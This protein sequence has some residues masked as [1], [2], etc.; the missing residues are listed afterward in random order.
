MPQ[1]PYVIDGVV[2]KGHNEGYTIVTTAIGSSGGETINIYVSSGSEL[3]TSQT[4]TLTHVSSKETMTYTTNGAGQ[5]LFD[6][7]NLTETYTEGDEIT[8]NIDTR[9]SNT[10]TSLDTESVA[11]AR[12]IVIVDKFGN[13]YDEKQPMMVIPA[14]QLISH[15][16]VVGNVDTA[17]TY[18]GTETRPAAETITFSDG[19]QYRRTLTYDSNSPKRIT[20][21]SKW[22]KL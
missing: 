14:E 22:Q 10:N 8:I 13:I 16:H 4:V 21:R 5:Y 17:Y 20:N 3:A 19:T 11:S 15:A 18:S 1:N 12:K 7:A 9:T 6:L 2:Y